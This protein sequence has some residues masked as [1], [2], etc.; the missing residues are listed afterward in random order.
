MA[1][2]FADLVKNTEIPETNDFG[3]YD[4]PP[5]IRWNNGTK[6]KLRNVPDVPGSFYASEKTLAGF[7]PGSVW[8]RVERYEDEVGYEAESVSLIFVTRRSQPFS[9]HKEGN[10]T[11][12]TYQQEW[13]PGVSKSVFTEYLV[14]VD[15]FGEGGI[16][17]GPAILGVKGMVGK[18]MEEELS[19]FRKEILAPASAIINANRKQP[20]KAPLFMFAVEIQPET[21]GRGYTFTDTGYGHAVNLPLFHYSDKPTDATFSEMYVGPTLL[22]ELKELHSSYEEWRNTKRTN[23]NEAAQQESQ[24]R[25]A[26]TPRRQLADYPQDEPDYDDLDF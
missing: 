16:G 9:E 1:T 19:R 7:E 6:S 2:G 10:K 25:Q 12:R 13:I 3:S 11:I 17:Y 8:Q 24:V 22:D 23:K 26:G 18:R 14:Y 20:V 4:G 5:R 15:G 21:N